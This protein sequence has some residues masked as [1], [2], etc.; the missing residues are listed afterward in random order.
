MNG[1]RDLN[2]LEK[3]GLIWYTDGSKTNKG[4]GPGM[5]HYGTRLKIIFGLGQCT[6][7]LQ[8]EVYA[9]RHEQLRI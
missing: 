1:K 7:V 6:T 5:Y 2:P 9:I 8:A 3:G 4:I